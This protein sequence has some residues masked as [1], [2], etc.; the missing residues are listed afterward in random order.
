MHPM[1]RSREFVT[2]NRTRIAFDKSGSRNRIA[3]P[4]FAVRRLLWF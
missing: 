2:T 4:R 3:A 1:S